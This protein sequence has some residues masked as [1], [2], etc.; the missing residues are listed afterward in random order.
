MKK[1]PYCFKLKQLIKKWNH[2]SKNETTR[3]GLYYI[4]A[5]NGALIFN[6]VPNRVC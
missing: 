4:L 1:L 3:L 5:E 6:L 2:F